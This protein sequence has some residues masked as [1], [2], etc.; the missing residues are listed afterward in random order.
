MQNYRCIQPVWMRAQERIY[1]CIFLFLFFK[2]NM[3]WVIRN[4]VKIGWHGHLYT[5]QSWQFIHHVTRE[6]E[7]N[8]WIYVAL[9]CNSR[10]RKLMQVN[11][12]FHYRLLGLQSTSC[13]EDES[14]NSEAAGLSFVLQYT[15]IIQ[16]TPHTNIFTW[17]ISW[18]WVALFI[19]LIVLIFVFHDRSTRCL[20]SVIFESLEE[21]LHALP[22][23]S[24]T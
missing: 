23:D 4:Y 13:D 9:C 5:L 11:R 19:R 15:H 22:W 8:N 16:P 18:I 1:R 20:S 10:G 2:E 7:H 12:I 24:F 21:C 6:R 3:L 17:R 14:Y